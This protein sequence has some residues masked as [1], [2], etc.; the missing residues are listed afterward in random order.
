MGERLFDPV[1]SDKL[2]DPQRVHWLPSSAVLGRMGVE[3]GWTIADVGAGT[4]YFARPLA[5]AVGPEG[6]VLA[7]DVQREMLARLLVKLAE[8]EAPSN[9]LPLPGD[10]DALPIADDACDALLLANL[11]HELENGP[12]VAREARRVVR[13]GGRMAVLDWEPVEPPP[14]PPLDHRVS[15]DAARDVLAAAGWVPS[16]PSR[17]GPYSWLL[18]AD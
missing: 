1:K 16:A 2:E 17:V 4:G 5:E 13:P 9:I 8:T 3:R 6:R 15:A 14:G 10:A 11:W 12:K 7:I 18:L